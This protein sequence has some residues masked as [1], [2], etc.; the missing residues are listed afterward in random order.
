MPAARFGILVFAG[1]LLVGFGLTAF[2]VDEREHALKF[3]FG[4]IVT[5]DYSPGLHFKVPIY[6]NIVK[7][8]N[9]ILTIDTPPEEIITAEKKTVYV[10]FFLKWRILSPVEYYIGT[11]GG[12]EDRAAG[13][14]LEI[15]K[16]KIRAEFSKRT[17]REVVSV[18]RT[19]LMDDMLREAEATA[20]ELG[21]ELVDLRVKRVEFSD[22]VA[23][24]VFIRM[25]QERN[26]IAT[27]LRAEGAEKAEQLR[28][29]ADR[30]RTVE[31]AK[32][33]RDAQKIR[34]V[35][36]AT[37]ANTYAKAYKKDAEFYAFY[38]S[39]EA[40]KSSIGQ[41]NDLLV[42]EPDSEFFRYL[43]DSSGDQK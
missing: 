24:S 42:L 39:I 9:Q 37:A 14:L 13:R 41:T 43:G 25:R 20:K 26:R 18:Q 3:R 34:G 7:L 15:I 12:R 17:V 21:V 33:Y 6:N 29:S 19:G 2:W 38:R 36:D 4:E 30:D 10:D 8:P 11:G 22:V 27:E 32:A 1:V 35:G 31:L 23:E 28:A 16:G 5:S 40:Y